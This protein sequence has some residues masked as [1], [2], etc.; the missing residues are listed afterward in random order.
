MSWLFLT[1][2][3]VVAWAALKYRRYTKRHAAA[4]N[5]VLA[6][7]TFEQLSRDQQTQIDE[8]AHEI[9]AG[10]MRHPPSDFQTEVHR[11]GWYALA[12]AELGIPPAIEE[13]KW[14]YVSNPWFAVFP[15]DSTFKLIFEYL[16]RKYDVEIHIDDKP[17]APWFSKSSEG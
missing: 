13:P 8:K 9:L 5:V 7:Y 17:G 11:F 14:S 15:G 6:K 4:M 1:I 3:L 10:L 16:K 12:M 2:L